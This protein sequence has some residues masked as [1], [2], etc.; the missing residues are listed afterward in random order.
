M[1]PSE[2]PFHTHPSERSFAYTPPMSQL[3]MSQQLDEIRNN[4]Q[5]KAPAATQALMARVKED[6]RQSGALEVAPKPGDTLPNFALPDTKGRIIRSDEW[7]EMGPLVLTFY[8]GL[9]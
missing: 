8:R 7:L 6:I 9:W 2:E 4:F 5:T 1:N 3:S